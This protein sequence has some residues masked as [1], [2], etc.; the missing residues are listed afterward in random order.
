MT[1]YLRHYFL[2]NDKKIR[3]TIDTNIS[4]TK[5]LENKFGFEKFIEDKNI[6]ELKYNIKDDELLRKNLNI[7][8]LRLSRNSKFIN[9]FSFNHYKMSFFRILNEFKKRLINKY[10]LKRPDFSEKKFFYKA[11]KINLLIE[12]GQDI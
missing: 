5:I 6:L 10:I 1:K 8:N 12:K 7:K 11:Y 2:S 9:S 3:A 4:Y